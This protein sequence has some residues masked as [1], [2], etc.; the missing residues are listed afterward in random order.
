MKRKILILY[1]VTFCFNL[2]AQEQ[3]QIPNTNLHLKLTS[4]YKFN[5][6]SMSFIGKEYE[7]SFIEMAGQKFNEQIEDF[8]DIELEYA[9]KGIDVVRNDRGMLGQYKALFLTLDTSPSIHQIFFGDNLYCAVVNV[10]ALDSTITINE[11]E[12][13]SLLSNIN[14]VVGSNSYVEEH[15]N[16]KFVTPN[17][18]WN[19]ISYM[20]N[21]FG[22]ENKTNTNVIMISQLPIT[23]LIGN[24]KENLANE[25]IVKLKNQIPDVIEGEK[26]KWSAKNFECHRSIL[27]IEGNEHVKLIYMVVFSNSESAF[28]FQGIAKE[29]DSITKSTF[30]AFLNNLKL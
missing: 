11:A 1:L 30:E 19:C 5:S 4:E 16:F 29:N 22:F 18:D 9:K 7:M 25:F 15:A 6:E 2:L 12:I 28:V 8:N 26:G 17:D 27:N 3:Q 23:S 13:N 10:I 21:T 24:S 20:T 14:Y